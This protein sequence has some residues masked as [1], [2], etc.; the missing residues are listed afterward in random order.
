MDC[1]NESLRESKINTIE[2]TCSSLQQEIDRER[3]EFKL[4]K[5][6]FDVLLVKKRVVED[7]LEVLKRKNQELEEQVHR[8]EN[9]GGNE[10]NEEERADRVNFGLSR[11]AKD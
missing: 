8:T 2:N 7:E 11:C 4:L 3:N 5:D 6:K 10:E 1:S 9:N